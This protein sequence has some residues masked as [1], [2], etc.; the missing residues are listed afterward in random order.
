MSLRSLI[1]N[2]VIKIDD[3]KAGTG[4]VL[5]WDDKR[6]DVHLHK[7]TNY[8]IEGKR[9]NVEIKIPLN[10]DRNIDIK[11]SGRKALKDNNIPAKLRKEIEDAFNDNK[12][13]DGFIEELLKHVDSYKTELESEK[14]AKEALTRI[15]KHFKLDWNADTIAKYTNEALSSLMLKYVDA[16]NDAVYCVKM[17]SNNITIGQNNGY[18]K[19][20]DDFGLRK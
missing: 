7:S 20:F 19:E 10:S 6:G 11:Y 18:T 14:R 9:Q 12:I 13:R 15:A 3:H 1:N 8:P 17:D 4:E 2:Q 16:N 5:N